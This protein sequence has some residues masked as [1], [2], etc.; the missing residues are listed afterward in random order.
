MQVYPHF[1]IFFSFYYLYLLVEKYLFQRLLK[2]SQS[3]DT[4][5]F[6]CNNSYIFYHCHMAINPLFIRY[7]YLLN[8]FK[9]SF[10]LPRYPSFYPL[11]S[12]SG[13]LKRY[14]KCS[15]FNYIFNYSFYL[16]LKYYHN[17]KLLLI[18][19]VALL[20]QLCHQFYTFYFG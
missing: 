8:A 18:L 12:R 2:I 16:F 19:V 11:I 3:I 7:R 20:T 10:F 9:M 5:G 15:F 4:T 14:V 1:S 6:C 17:C 13:Y